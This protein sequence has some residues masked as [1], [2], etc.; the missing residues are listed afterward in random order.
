MSQV[1]PALAILAAV[2]RNGVIGHDGT[3]P[4][5]LPRDLARFKQLSMGHPIIMGRKTFDS[6][7][8]ALP[9]RRSIVISRQSQRQLPAGVTRV[10]S[11]DEAILEAR[12][13]G[14][15][16]LAFV[17]GGRAVYSAA[18]P[19]AT[20]LYLTRVEADVAGDVLFPDVDW[21]EWACQHR[22]HHPADAQN[23]YDLTFELWQRRLPAT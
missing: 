15:S 9:G 10:G 11:L 23:E 1:R 18:L 7:G 13:S 2:A 22:E 21:R 8:R 3:L 5:H 14:A 20:Q 19:L 16:Q 4:W 12:S 6:I 17:I